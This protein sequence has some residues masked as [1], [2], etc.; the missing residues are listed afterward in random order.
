MGHLIGG[1]A[2]GSEKLAV[3]HLGAHVAFRC[4]SRLSVLLFPGNI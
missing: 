3:E 2:G 1:F 4:L